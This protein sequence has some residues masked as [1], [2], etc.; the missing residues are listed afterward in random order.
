M[1][2]GLYN[3]KI[4]QGK[5]KFCKCLL[6]DDGRIVYAGDDLI[7]DEYEMYDLKG[8]TVIPG[9]NDSH[10]HVFYLAETY[11]Q[12]DIKDAKSIDELIDITKKFIEDNP[13]LVKGGVY[14]RGY[15]DD[16]FSDKRLP[17][18]NDLD[19]I[20]TDIPIVLNRVCG[21]MCS[22]NSLALKMMKER[23]DL[24]ELPDGEVV[25]GRDGKPDGIFTEN[26]VGKCISLV[27]DINKN[28]K[29]I[30][31]KK[32]MKYL[33]S[34]GVTSIQSND[35]DD[36]EN[37]DEVKEI[38]EDLYKN[39]EGLVRYYGQACFGEDEYESLKRVL[40]ND[41]YHLGYE[42]EMIRMGPLKLFKDGSLGARTAEMY[43]DYHDDKGNRGVVVHTKEE[44][45]KLTLLANKYGISVMTHAI[46]DKAVDEVCD[47]YIETDKEGYNRY[48]NCINHCQITSYEMLKKMAENSICVAYQPVFLE[49]DLH[50]VKDRV[51]EE[52][53]RTSYAYKTLKDMGAPVSFGTDCPVEDCNGFMNLYCAINRKDFNNSET[54]NPEERMSVMEAIDAY[55]SGS[56]YQSFEEGYKGLLKEGYYADLVVLEED[57]FNM[58][59][60]KIKDL[61]A[62]MTMVNGKVVYHR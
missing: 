42:N 44:I 16:Y 11:A 37:D 17:D 57:I 22:V 33:L 26:S 12:A 31:L 28:T 32:A 36:F 40:E 9:L 6:I 7:K 45:K 60:E 35:F 24:D 4:Y 8:K 14:A 43:E 21:H 29:K 1:K 56:A 41:G 50:I 38:L 13:E 48:R 10:M 39:E 46:G 2:K 47:A 19:K 3:G 52:L 25:Y 20:S 18:K 58:D 23:Y 53:A 61:K 34:T 27:E 62:Y 5:G 59:P 30:L 15:N 51:G 54:Y 55:T 49:Y